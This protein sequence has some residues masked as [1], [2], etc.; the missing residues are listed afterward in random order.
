VTGTVG[1]LLMGGKIRFSK[2]EHPKF[3]GHVTPNEEEYQKS[4]ELKFICI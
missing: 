4:V 1:Q 3:E 2:V